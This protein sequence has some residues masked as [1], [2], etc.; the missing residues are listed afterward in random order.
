MSET[1]Y[2]PEKYFRDLKKV[3][4]RI[5][6]YDELAILDACLNYLHAPAKDEIERLRRQPWLV[7]LVIKWTFVGK[8]KI[9]Y[10]RDTLDNKN[11]MG[12]MQ[13]TINLGSLVKMPSEYTHLNLFMRNM[14]FQQFW[15]QHSFSVPQYGRQSIIF[16]SLP[17]NHT[18]KILFR[19]KHGIS[20]NDF[21]AL[22][23]A[24]IAH[25]VD[26][27]SYSVELKWFQPLSR[28]FGMNTVYKFL[29]VVS[30]E[31]SELQRSLTRHNESK[32]G[33]S[34][35]YEQTPFINFPLIKHDQKYICIHPNILYRCVEHFLYDSM[36]SSDPS[37]FM[38]YFGKM[39][40]NY[41]L[42]GLNYA[43]IMYYCENE[44]KKHI[45]ANVKCVD[46][47]IAGDNSNIFIDAKAVE[48]PY[49]GKVS[50][51]PDVIRGKIKNTAIKAIEQAYDLNSYLL[52]TTNV[53]LPQFKEQSFLLVVTYK[54]LYL[55]NGEVIY[56]SMAKKKIDEITKTIDQRA[57]IELSRIYFITIQ[58]FDH[59]MSLEKNHGIKI[60][61]VIKAA[62]LNDSEF[63]TKKF[64]FSQHIHTL[65][66]NV[67][68]PEYLENATSAV[69]EKFKE[70][71]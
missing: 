25:F 26:R 52:S 45:P 20:C 70:K 15:Y 47:V 71:A 4:S 12:I 34:E 54:E 23:F 39:F 1:L 33:Y 64:E 57:V 27:K 35:Y 8:G 32:G 51:N 43:P 38:K 60:E 59:L 42:I 68:T 62:I 69:L 11:F 9:R 5:K 21:I 61:D 49:L 28:V 50:D 3:K 10:A 66:K 17:D 7:L 58:D 22:S 41:L 24:L 19:E 36:K 63:K 48:M 40:E 18:L 14:A 46:Y 16:G 31:S 37:K 67:K 13:A 56:E 44:L 30:I 29:N 53:E 2:M 6:N 55:G 65:C